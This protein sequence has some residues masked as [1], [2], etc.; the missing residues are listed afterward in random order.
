[1]NVASACLADQFP[2]LVSRCRT[3]PSWAIAGGWAV[4]L[5]LGYL[6]RDH[7]DLEIAIPRSQQECLRQQWA[8]WKFE[9][10]DSGVSL[11]WPSRGQLQLP[12]HEINAVGQHGEQLEILLNE[13]DD[14]RW[15]YRRDNRISLL[16]DSAFHETGGIRYLSPLIVLLYKSKYPRT[17][18][19]KDFESL[20]PTLNSAD[21]QWLANAIQL[22][23]GS[24]AWAARLLSL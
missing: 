7:D 20:L 17:K 19:E 24:S 11:P 8:G 21:R 2:W 22:S 18:D 3:L 6:S 15:I 16:L 9:Y 5:H 14:N 10:V 23:N 13:I 4:D 12:I 1:M